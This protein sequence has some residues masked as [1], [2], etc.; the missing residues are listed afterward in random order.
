MVAGL[1]M[2]GNTDRASADLRVHTSCSTISGLR[3]RYGTARSV[4]AQICRSPVCI[5][6]HGETRHHSRNALSVAMT[7]SAE[8]QEF[9]IRGW[10]PESHRS[11]IPSMEGNTNYSIREPTRLLSGLK[12]KT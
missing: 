4:D 11:T 12:A 7:N 5:T 9:W 3:S 10:I 2:A 8:K 1:A 6:G